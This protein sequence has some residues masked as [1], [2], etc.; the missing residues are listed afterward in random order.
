MNLIQNEMNAFIY[1]NWARDK[2]SIDKTNPICW[3]LGYQ[4]YT[5][6]EP[7][8]IRDIGPQLRCL[9]DK[10]GR[11]SSF[12]NSHVGTCI[13]VLEC[14]ASIFHGHLA[15]DIVRGIESLQKKLKTHFLQSRLLNVL[16]M[17]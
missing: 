3:K 14:P 7:I 4:V 1:K 5:G 12:S 11:T 17:P 10:K 9:T 16:I 13:P 8:P 15:T 6:S 2:V